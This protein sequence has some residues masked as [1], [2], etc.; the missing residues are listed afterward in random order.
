MKTLLTFCLLMVATLSQGKNYSDTLLLEE[1]VAT[2]LNHNADLVVS[3]NEE[4]VANNNYSWGNAGL[5]PTLRAN[6]GYTRSIQDVDINFASEN[7]PPINR[8][9]ALSEQYNASVELSYNIFN[10][11]RKYNLYNSLSLQ[12]DISG[13]RTRMTA[14]NTI[15]QTTNLYLEASR[16]SLQLRID[17]FAISLSQERL[18]RLQNRYTYG[19]STRLEIFNAEVDLDNDSVAYLNTLVALQ[20][21]KRDL[22][23]FVGADTISDNYAVVT[24][25]MIIEDL[26][27]EEI[28]KKAKTNN[29]SILIAQLQRDNANYQVDINKAALLPSINATVAYRYNKQ[30]NEAGFIETQTQT[31]FTGNLNISYDI[32]SG[33]TRFNDIENARIQVENSEERR[34]EAIRSVKANVRNSYNTYSTNLR[35]LSFAIDNLETAEL[36]YERSQEAYFNGQITSTEVRQAQLNLIRAQN[37]IVNYQIAVKRAEI[38]LYQL[39]GWLLD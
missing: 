28:F 6:A 4:R 10:G 35:L 25:F 31:G 24:N 11:F 5:L 30:Q 22:L 26:E 8:E 33:F 29:T 3:R 17:K 19:K 15:A 27:F 16:L 32:F 20:N 38:N 13:I 23:T 2:A 21:Q 37:R 34:Q 36:N 12:E 18:Q 39:A 14:E 7:Q 1:A 9:G